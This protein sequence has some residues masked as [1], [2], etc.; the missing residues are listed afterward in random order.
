MAW[1]AWE[2][3]GGPQDTITRPR[4]LAPGRTIHGRVHWLPRDFPTSV[5]LQV[6]VEGETHA[7]V[8]REPE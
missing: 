5:R 3:F 4:P 6:E 7:F 1:S 8:F 2:Y